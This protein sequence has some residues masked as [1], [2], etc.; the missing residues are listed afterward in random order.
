[1][2]KKGLLAGGIIAMSL[3]LASCIAPNKDIKQVETFKSS[4]ESIN[5]EAKGDSGTFYR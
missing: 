4:Y 3:C 2:V 1:M 5:N